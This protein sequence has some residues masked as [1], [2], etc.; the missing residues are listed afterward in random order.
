MNKIKE[1]L[2]I[3]CL[4]TILF[5][6]NHNV[7][8]LDEPQEQHE[9]TEQVKTQEDLQREKELEEQEHQRLLKQDWSVT[10]DKKEMGKKINAYFKNGIRS[11]K[12]WFSKPETGVHLDLKAESKPTTLQRSPEV[13]APEM[14]KRSEFESI[15]RAPAER[16]IDPNSLEGRR[17]AK[18][19]TMQENV[20]AAEK[21]A[22][23]REINQ[24]K[25]TERFAQE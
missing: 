25:A 13:K 14:I 4:I 18:E 20:D 17:I 3:L 23:E 7:L 1:K 9:P 8:S 19:K 10:W 5:A 12:S 6:H 22:T 2:S 15:T 16:H 11:I 21:Q 24:R